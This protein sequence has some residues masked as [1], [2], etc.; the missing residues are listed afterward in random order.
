[1]LAF[2]GLG[3]NEGDTLAALRAAAQA[4]GRHGVEVLQASS[5]WETAPQGR[6][7]DQADF[8]NACLRVE[9]SL[10]PEELLD[11]CKVVEREGGRAP[12]GPKH[13]PR[14]IDIDVLLVDGVE[15]RSKRMVLPHP[16]LRTRRFVLEPLL[17]LEPELRLPDGSALAPLLEAVRDQR[18]TRRGLLLAPS[19]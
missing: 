1:V 17:E 14:P 15:H 18:V 13:G 11:V 10:S 9:A 19:D 16:E 5:V 8:M 6:V 3:S 7:L 2:L 4:L 12:G